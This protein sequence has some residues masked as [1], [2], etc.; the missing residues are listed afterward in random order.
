MTE[1]VR[2]HDDSSLRFDFDNVLFHLVGRISDDSGTNFLSGERDH[3]WHCY[4]KAEADRI[5]Q[6]LA[7]CPEVTV[8]ETS[9]D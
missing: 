7:T 4:D 6:R 3:G 1:H 8:V 2:C 5:R 9:N